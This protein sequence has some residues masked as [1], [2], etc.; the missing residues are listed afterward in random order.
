MKLSITK[1]I[2]NARVLYVNGEECY[3]ACGLNLLIYKSGEKKRVL[4]KLPASLKERILSSFVFTRLG[5]RLGIHAAIPLSEGRI[6]AVMK[7]RFVLI[8]QDGSSRV[9]DKIHRGNKPASRAICVLPDGAIL[10]GEYLLNKKRES[11]VAIYRSREIED[12]FEKIYEFPAG[13]VR[14]IHFIQWDLYE[15]CLWMGTGD[16]DDESF[17]YKS[18]DYG[19]SWDRINGGSQLWRAVSIII[20]PDALFWGT[21]AGSDAGTTPNFIVR[22]DK[23]TKE[24]S[25]IQRVQG[26]CHGA[27]LLL[28]S[29]LCISTGVEGGE[30]EADKYAHLWISENG[31]TWREVFE[32]KKNI[33]PHIIQFGVMRMPPGCETSN[34]L[35][36][37]AFALG[38]AREAWFQAEIV[39]EL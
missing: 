6:L 10:Y 7:R 30:N 26:P 38:R 34:K 12:G 3:V 22:F 28:N 31:V 4:S 25:A 18:Y 39:S 13:I 2:N 27:C 24:L 9:I 37:T 17:I 19:L 14:H 36:F 11:P 32:R 29:V 16:R 20:T 23:K 8:E 1:K 35:N 21:D 15:S 5:L 33:W